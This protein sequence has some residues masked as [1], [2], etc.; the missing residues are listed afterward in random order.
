MSW[1][2]SIG[3]AQCLKKVTPRNPKYEHIKTK[4][5]TGCS[6]S[7]Y[8]EREIKSHHKYRK[9]ELFKRLKETTFVNL[10]LQVASIAG[11]E[12]SEHNEESHRPEDCLSV[13]SEA[14]LQRL[15]EHG[16]GSPHESL[17]SV[18]PPER[19]SRAAEPSCFPR[20]TLQSVISG[21]GE[22]DLSS[23]MQNTA[24]ETLVPTPE[25]ADR[26]YPDCPYLLLDVRD[27]ELYDH[28][29]IISSHSYPTI[30]L[31]RTMNPYTKEVLDYRN[32]MGKIIILYDE[33]EKLATQAAT[34]MCQRGF[35]NLYVLS[36]GLKA[37]AQKFPR[38]MTT[39][40]LPA[41]CLPAPASKG[42]KNHK[43]QQ[44]Q[45]QQQPAEKRWRFTSDELSIIQERL[46]ETISSNT[47]S[48][49]SSRLSSSSSMSTASSARTQRT[50]S[51]TARVQSSRPWK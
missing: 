11:L 39:G 25:P 30:S 26:P 28:C 46:E 48:R 42:K 7:K 38:G 17:L 5:D 40:S 1:E 35:E 3:A 23:H 33:D 9:D 41:S 45:Q 22:L 12:E 15:C 13:V 6:L 10:V 27:R 43:V 32:A 21:V 8:I 4:L 16:N 29:H 31:C 34:I 44:Q 47:S 19:I 36:G 51:T 2:R 50:V 49:L 37:V 20:S 24:K 18:N 14:E